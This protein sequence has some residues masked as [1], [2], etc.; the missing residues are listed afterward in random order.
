MRR[1]AV[2]SWHC[3]KPRSVSIYH[4]C[5]GI[6]LRS[7]RLP[8]HRSASHQASRASCL[9]S[10]DRARNGRRRYAFLEVRFAPR[11]ETRCSSDERS[12]ARPVS[13]VFWS[14]VFWPWVFGLPSAMQ[15]RHRLYPHRRRHRRSCQQPRIVGKATASV[16]A[17]GSARAPT[18]TAPDI[19]S[20]TTPMR[21]GR[22]QGTGGKKWIAWTVAVVGSD[23]RGPGSS[24][25]R[26]RSIPAGLAAPFSL[27][28]DGADFTWLV[29][30]PTLC[31]VPTSV[32]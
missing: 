6:F 30:V 31:S 21:T 5:E 25:P 17:A 14:W 7:P 20:T 18:A 19:A 10:Q 3:K 9:V 16:I 24:S 27:A 12:S 28:E 22:G 13:W 11:K 23:N 8:C 29:N 2:A 32:R 1:R 4:R 15:G 26:T